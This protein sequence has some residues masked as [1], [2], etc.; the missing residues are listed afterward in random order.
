VL[1]CSVL[2]IPFEIAPV[3]YESPSQSSSALS[4]EY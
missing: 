1:T 2:L 3:L 4:I